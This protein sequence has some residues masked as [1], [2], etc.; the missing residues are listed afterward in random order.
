MPRQSRYVSPVPTVR[1]IDNWHSLFKRNLVQDVDHLK[2][3]RKEFQTTLNRSSSPFDGILAVDSETTSLN[4]PDADLV[5]LSFCFQP[6]IG[7]YIPISHRVGSNLPFKVL[8][9][10]NEMM[11]E[12]KRVLFF[13]YAFDMRVFRKAINTNPFN[14]NHFDVQVLLW[15]LDTNL[16]Y[17]SLKQCSLNHL[18]IEQSTYEDL[19]GSSSLDFSYLPVQDAANYAVMDAIC[20]FLLY[21]RFY[22]FYQ[23]EVQF[24][25]DVDNELVRVMMFNEEVP[26]PI[27][28]RY[29]ATLYDHYIQKKEQKLKQ[30]HQIA[31][32]NF[33]VD[34]PYQVQQILRMI[35]VPLTIRTSGGHYSTREDILTSF[36]DKYPLV[37]LLL[38]YRELQVLISRYIEPFMKHD[39]DTIHIK[40][41]T[42]SAPTGRLASGGKETKIKQR[43]YFF[44]FNIQATLKPSVQPYSYKKDNSPNAILGYSFYP[45]D[46]G[47]VFAYV[48]N[49]I[50]S[51]FKP[52]PG[53][54]LVSCDYDMEE[55]IIAANLSNDPVWVDAMLKG[56][57]V[58]AVEARRYFSNNSKPVSKEQR[59]IAKTLN[60]GSIYFGTEYTLSRQLRDKSMSEC[61][62]LLNKWRQLH[63]VYLSY[64]RKR[65]IEGK[66]QGY[67]KTPM[68]RI[69]RL[70][71]WHNSPRPSD[72][73]FAER[74]TA[75]T[76][77][78]GSAAD[79]MRCVLVRLFYEV[80]M[81]PRYKSKIY[82]MASIHDS[83]EH[84]VTKEPNL[85]TEIVNKIVHIM[86]DFPFENWRVPFTI[87]ISVGTDWGCMFP[88]KYENG[89]W[90]PVE[91]E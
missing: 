35:G 63:H 17:P 76:L 78:Q 37:K 49:N 31:P 14:I 50:R 70:A 6:P 16:P 29:A 73:A 8:D 3:I 47:N 18:G 27:D 67:V 33:E 12:A 9:T 32:R 28:R 36:S 19:V 86:T 52:H 85:F 38:E 34:S 80:Y 48:D 55:L 66:K 79:I 43:P 77:V 1:K 87:S 72:N 57:D 46:N 15:N 81:N 65:I 53:H 64:I 61:R 74:T 10:I 5:G 41:S 60:Y 59:E 23:E 58:H 25:V 4:I 71:F 44:P 45:D 83:L 22:S 26:I 2:Q 20:T 89:K 42:V 24:I 7:Y 82:F 68:Q 88:F 21:K 30:I 91:K 11:Y 69:R 54:Y 39:S 90:C 40:Y 75:N 62:E 56:E 84:S 51:I 13:N